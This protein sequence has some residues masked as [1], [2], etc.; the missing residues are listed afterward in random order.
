MAQLREYE[1][2]IHDY[3]YFLVRQ[4]TQ[5]RGTRRRVNL[6]PLTRDATRFAVAFC[7]F[8]CS[9]SIITVFSREKSRMEEVEEWHKYI[10]EKLAL[11][12]GSADTG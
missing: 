2:R 3:T 5:E 8:R 11:T 10:E 7:W 4:E 12:S 6:C 9:S 1:D